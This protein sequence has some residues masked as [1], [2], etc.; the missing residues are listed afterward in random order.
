MIFTFSRLS[1]AFH[2][3]QA[4]SFSR[5]MRMHPLGRTHNCSEFYLPQPSS[6]SNADAPTLPSI[7]P[8]VQTSTLLYQAP[9]SIPSRLSSTYARYAFASHTVARHFL[10]FHN[11]QAPTWPSIEPRMETLSLIIH[12]CFSHLSLL[13]LSRLLPIY[14]SVILAFSN[15]ALTLF[16]ACLAACILTSLTCDF[17]ATLIASRFVPAAGATNSIF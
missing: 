5:L 3:Y 11:H 4:S 7:E 6:S 8:Y 15:A 14:A 9:S 13:L 12:L 16:A 2:K 10:T 1:L 17:S